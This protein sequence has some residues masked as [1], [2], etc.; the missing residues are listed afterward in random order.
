MN[1]VDKTGELVDRYIK[2]KVQ[3]LKAQAE[4]TKLEEQ[5]KNLKKLLIEIA[6]SAKVQSLGG[7]I[8]TV[9]YKRHMKPKVEDWEKLYE[10]IMKHGAFEL[11]QRRIGEKAV[12]ER[13][14]DGIVIPGVVK[15][16][17]DDLTISG[18]TK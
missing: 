1:A 3:R 18:K 5:E 8:G 14:E 11:I 13:W 4:V 17:I 10:Y 12:E 9:N 6:I 15:F 7:S 2:T 16:P